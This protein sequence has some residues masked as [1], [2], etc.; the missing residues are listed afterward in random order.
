MRLVIQRVTSASVTVAGEPVAAIDL[1]LL[2][3]VGFGREDEVE[4]TPSSM[5]SRMARKLAQVRIFPNET[6]RLD[7]DVADVDGR[8]LAVSQFTLHAD[9]RKGRRPSFHPAADPTRAEALFTAFI[10]ELESLLPNRVATGRFGREM[11]V[12][13]RNWGPVTLIWD[14]LDA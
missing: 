5:L 7:R 2:V 3:L 10:A 13:L 8:I 12:A 6:G 14:S 9:C 1:G 11:D 4:P